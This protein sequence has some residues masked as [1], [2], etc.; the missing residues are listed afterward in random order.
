MGFKEQEVLMETYALLDGWDPKR[1]LPVQPTVLKLI[2]SL[3][4]CVR[5]RETTYL[6]VVQPYYAYGSAAGDSL[7]EGHWMA[8]FIAKSIPLLQA[9]PE[10]A[11]AV[12]ELFQRRASRTR[13]REDVL[14]MA[15]IL[16]L[17]DPLIQRTGTIT[18][19][20]FSQRTDGRIG[21]YRTVRYSCQ[22]RIGEV[23]RNI[24]DPECVKGHAFLPLTHKSRK[25]FVHQ[26][27]SGKGDLYFLGKP[28]ISNL[29]RVLER[30]QE[31]DKLKRTAMSIS[32]SHLFVEENGA[33]GVADIAGFGEA[34][35]LAQE[36][37][38]NF[39]QTGTEIARLFRAR[40]A[41]YFVSLT[42]S[43]GISQ[44]KSTGDGFLCAMP[45]RKSARLSIVERLSRLLSGYTQTL[46]VFDRMTE[47]AATA[48]P[49]WDKVIGSRLAL[50]YGDYR[51]G[52]V[53]GLNS[54]A[55]DFE[56]S[57]I[58]QAARLEAG[59]KR[60]IQRLPPEV[61]RK[62]RHWI[63]VDSAFFD[64]VGTDEIRAAGFAEHS[65]ISETEKE[66]SISGY[67]FSRIV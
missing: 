32:D 50:T 1:P 48:S 67:V 41:E 25:K 66:S 53:G 59:L 47:L 45:I 8:P 63:A 33:V 2:Y 21:C 17:G 19:L 44:A 40:L 26:D 65:E 49:P 24:T 34:C 12:D 31:V 11:G 10:T 64:G 37:M 56:G 60:M 16:G 18:E 54:L 57:T 36:R 14:R 35:K 27:P 38:P 7:R 30:D 39:F 28:L 3:E 61:P 6:L 20:K 4:V 42:G 55:A 62:H 52:R 29:Q 23:T 5:F 15:E 22:A 46:D 9:P 13:E 51:Y 43:A 58:V